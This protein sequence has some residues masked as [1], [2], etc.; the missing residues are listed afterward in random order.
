MA[1]FSSCEV[2]SDPKG[3]GNVT[4]QRRS[5]QDFDEL[6]I[7]GVLTVYL[8]QSDNHKVEVVTD[9]NLQYIVNVESVNGILY[10]RT[11]DD[12]D[13][14][15]TRMDVYISTPDISA[16]R[17]DGVT[18]MYCRDTLSLNNVD[19][20]KT[21]TGFMEFR[22]ILSQLTIETYDIG[23]MELH[24]KAI[25]TKIRNQMVGDI[26]AYGFKTDD[27]YL[28]HGGTGEI[29]IYVSDSLEVDISGV[30]DVHC[31]GNPNYID[32]NVS[33]VGKLFIEN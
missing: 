8:Q 17:L 18:A 3:S 6:D 20:E 4:T 26:F 24:G 15:A 31:K 12:V 2:E 32:K 1:L 30:G 11:N 28:S 10:I 13:F 14:Q 5:V 25:T 22:A 29:E 33:G 27:M 21:N 19:I 16:I 7:N 9:E 23:D